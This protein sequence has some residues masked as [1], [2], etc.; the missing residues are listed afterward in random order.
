MPKPFC[1]NPYDSKKYQPSMQKVLLI[2]II[3]SINLVNKLWIRVL[4]IVHP[5]LDRCLPESILY[6]KVSLLERSFHHF[7]FHS[8]PM[9]VLPPSTLRHDPVIKLAESAAR[10]AIASA[11]SRGCPIRPRACVFALCFTNSAYRS[12]LMPSRF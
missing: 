9:M 4:T 5:M 8:G 2:V 1:L 12:G 7:I 10:N 6:L 3:L 11:T